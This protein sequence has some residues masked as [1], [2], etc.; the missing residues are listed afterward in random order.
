MSDDRIVSGQAWADFCDNLR[1]AGNVILSGPDDPLT[2]AEGFRY[3]TGLVRAGLEVFVDRND[4]LAP[5]LMRVVHETVKMGADNP[6]N[7]YQNASISGAY[8]YR[9]R[10]KRNSVHYLAF[11]ALIGHYGQ[12]RGMPEA[13][14]LDA[15]ELLL[16]PDG[17]FEIEVSCERSAGAK[18]WLRM[19]PET[20]TLIVRQTRLDP[21]AEALAELSIERVGDDVARQAL[22]PAQME[23]GL[24]SAGTLVAG[25]AM[26]FQGWA[27]GFA[28]NHPNKLP[29]FDQALSNAMGGVPD[30]AYYHSYWRLEDDEAL[31]IDA[32]PPPCDHWNFQL[33]NHW[34]ESLDYRFH[35]IHVNSKTATYRQDGS[36]RVVV[37]HQDPGVPNWIE[38]AHHRFGTM[39]WRWVKPQ[40]LDGAP[41]PSCRVVKLAEVKGLP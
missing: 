8:R 13:G 34:M 17:S 31:V 22:T 26:I 6:D 12:G 9:I 19:T 27:S 38:T 39:C 14:H 35:R 41:E 33:N 30:I 29:R 37:A 23:T 2:R 18:N 5:T 11:A 15:S 24:T 7:F 4:P 21:K 10:G 40:S 36:V 3:L 25:A 28:Q 20:G 32:A 1:N 16:E